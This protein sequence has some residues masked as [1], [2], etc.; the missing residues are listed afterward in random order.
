MASRNAPVNAESL[1]IPSSEEQRGGER[2]ADAEEPPSLRVEH[3]RIPTIR[4]MQIY[5]WQREYFL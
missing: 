1:S 2:E 5:A 4:F 3:T